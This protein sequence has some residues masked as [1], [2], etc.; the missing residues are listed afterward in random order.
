[1]KRWTA[2]RAFEVIHKASSQMAR[3]PK[4]WQIKIMKE[5]FAQITVFGELR[6]SDKNFQVWEDKDC[7][8]AIIDHILGEASVLYSG[9]RY[10][11]EPVDE[12]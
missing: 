2:K 8:L 1:M 4:S 10:V 6:Y 3:N 12:G 9:L 5:K 11:I 7:N